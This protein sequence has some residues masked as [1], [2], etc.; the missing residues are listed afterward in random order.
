M[1][2]PQDQAVLNAIVAKGPDSVTEE[3]R[4][5]LLARKSYLTVD[6]QVAFGVTDAPA[7]EEPAPA[8]KSRKSA[9]TDEA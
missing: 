2:N 9:S 7:A 4:A 5:V 6:Q 8:K 3:E 1:L